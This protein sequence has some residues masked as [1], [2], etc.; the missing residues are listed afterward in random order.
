MTKPL[1]SVIMSV[2]KESFTFLREAIESI[3]G[4]T[5]K[6]SEF[7]IVNDNPENPNLDYLKQL[8]DNNSNVKLICN[9]KI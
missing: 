5:L 1:V 8:E 7:I 3:L 2:Y 6:G 9:K 4:Q